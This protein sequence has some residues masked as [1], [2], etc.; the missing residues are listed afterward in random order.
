MSF[1]SNGSS[2]GGSNRVDYS[3]FLLL[4]LSFIR[5]SNLHAR[6]MHRPVRWAPQNLHNPLRMHRNCELVFGCQVAV[7][8]FV[9]FCVDVDVVFVVVFVLL[10]LV[11][12]TSRLGHDS[13]LIFLIEVPNSYV[14]L[15]RP[16]RKWMN[17]KKRQRL[18]F[19]MR[20]KKMF[21]ERNKE[22]IG[23]IERRFSIKC[24][25]IHL[26]C[27]YQWLRRFLGSRSRL[28]T[29][30][31]WHLLKCTQVAANRHT[32]TVYLKRWHINCAQRKMNMQFINTINNVPSL[33]R[34]KSI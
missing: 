31:N 3:F 26:I 20:D 30:D 5:V 23:M 34:N 16:L 24:A 4:F 19:R 17:F 7:F 10:V 27:L 25:N 6:K 13:V 18:E 28:A 29:I 33:T 1:G 32:S 12:S 15:H 9:G 22:K 21:K 8:S 14:A 2:K 11:A